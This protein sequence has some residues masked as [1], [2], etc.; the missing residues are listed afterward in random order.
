MTIVHIERAAD[1]GAAAFE[2]FVPPAVGD[3]PRPTLFSAEAWSATDGSVETGIWEATPGTFSRAVV[4]A[5]FCHFIRGH[6]TFVTEDGR[7]YE[8]R[9]GDAAYFPPH[10]RGTWTIHATL[11]KTYCIWRQAVLR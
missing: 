3:L 11:R 5:E 9:A 7:R 8:L 1:L 2:T 4:D 10:T 6:A